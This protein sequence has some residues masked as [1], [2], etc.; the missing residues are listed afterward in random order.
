MENHM[1]MIEKVARAIAASQGT[2]E[3]RQ[4]LVAARCAV[5]ALRDPT[6]E[7]LD[8]ACTG[9]PDWGYLPEEWHAMINHVLREPVTITRQF[10]EIHYRPS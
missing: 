3:W 9:L 8:A 10:E 6:P 2:S 1:Q 4:S 7:M 5:R